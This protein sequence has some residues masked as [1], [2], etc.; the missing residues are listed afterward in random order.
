MPIKEIV[1][2]LLDK[3]E[4]CFPETI[5]K[6]RSLNKKKSTQATTNSNSSEGWQLHLFS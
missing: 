5:K 6:M 3:K 1:D 2:S 4:L